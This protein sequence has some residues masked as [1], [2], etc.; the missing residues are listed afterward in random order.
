MHISDG[1]LSPSVSVGS[2][3]CA[4]GVMYTCV[5][6]IRSEDLPKIAVVASSFFVASLVHVPLGPTSV[7]LLLIGL[8]GAMLGRGA[9]PSVVL[10]L[11]LQCLLFGYGGITALGAN[12]LMMG[13]PALVAG[14]IY[15]RL[16]GVETWSHITAAAVAGA[17][18]TA[19]AAVSLAALLMTS[20]EDFFGVARVSLWAHLPV[21]VIEAL[22][23]AFVVSFIIKVRPQLVW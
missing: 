4:A 10:G 2:Y 14:G 5:R 8:V 6:G 21:M 1:V 7:H 19:L 11:T 18:G 22:V 12:S 23:S 17:L 15:R 13:L 9:F 20:G 16:K 3:I